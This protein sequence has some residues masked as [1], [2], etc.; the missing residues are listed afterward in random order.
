MGRKILH[1]SRLLYLFLFVLMTASLP[2][3]DLSKAEPQLFNFG[4]QKIFRGCSFSH[5]GK[6]FYFD[7]YKWAPYGG[8][9]TLLQLYRSVW[10]DGAWSTAEALEFLPGETHHTPVISPDGRRLY[11]TSSAPAP[12][13]TQEADQNAWYVDVTPNGWGAPVFIHEI[14]TD[15]NERITSVTADG[16]IFFTSNRP[17]GSG[18]SDIYFSRRQGNGFSTPENIIGFNSNV[19]EISVA[20]DDRMRFAIIHR[21]T[22]PYTIDLFYSTYVD[23]TWTPIVP[24]KYYRHTPSAAAAYYSPRFV[25]LTP[26]SNMLYFNINF[27]AY[28]ISTEELLEANGIPTKSFGFKIE[29]PLAVAKRKYGEP[30]PFAPNQIQTN[31]G[32]RITADGKKVYTAQYLP[33][34]YDNALPGEQRMVVMESVLKNG[35]W[36]QMT[37]V[38]F[39][40]PRVSFEYNP[41]LSPDG[42]KLFFNTRMNTPGSMSFNNTLNKN[43]LAFVEQ[44]VNG[45]WGPRHFLAEIATDSADEDY[46]S[47]ARNGRLYFHSHKP[48]SDDGELY[49]SELVDGRY[50][51]PRILSE[52]G[53]PDEAEQHAYVDPDERFIIF[54]RSTTQTKK[55]YQNDLY[56]SFREHGK[57]RK[58]R[59]L[60]KVNTVRD[61]ELTPSVSADGKTF[62]FEQNQNV[63][64]VEF[65]SILLP[66]EIDLLKKKRP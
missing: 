42:K 31:N 64:Q 59:S 29:K 9:P 28:S 13:K 40:D 38:E 7:S 57:W 15:A 51:P 52:L 33:K 5:D 16:T 20:V 65:E 53:L 4:R 14:N 55:N 35:R 41:V 3:Q 1:M 8:N 50:G 32:F 44:D 23:G 56:I 45:R 10:K 43:N 25:H 63:M 49:V 34:F 30:V 48:A 46:G 27:F 60:D 58:P 17:G 39:N 36:Q 54:L 11:F 37:P 18:D 61:W 22:N 19:E 62:Y 26:G 21:R 66:D 24:L 6:T 47:I 2:A 12:G